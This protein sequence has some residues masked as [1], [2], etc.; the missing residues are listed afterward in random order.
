MRDFKDTDVLGTS[1]VA[2][3]FNVDTATVRRWA[4]SGRL[5]GKRLAGGR[6]SWAFS[7]ISVRDFSE[8]DELERDLSKGGRPRGSK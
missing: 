2:D 4:E 1:D 6:G 8:R 5:V 7:G 3:F